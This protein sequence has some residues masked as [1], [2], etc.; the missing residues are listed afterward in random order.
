MQPLAGDQRLADALAVAG[1]TAAGHRRRRVVL[2]ALGEE[3]AD[4]S[5]LDP[6]QA[7]RYLETLRVP[8]VIWSLDPDAATERGWGKTVDISSMGRI[9]GALREL[10]RRLDRQWIV[11]LDGVHLPQEIQLKD[12]VEGVEIAR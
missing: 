10:R 9:D 2:L 5:Q 3:P 11:W 12:A 7:R 4:G 1:L 8:L 6:A